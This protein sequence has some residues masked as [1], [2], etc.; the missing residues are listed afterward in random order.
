[1]MLKRKNHSAPV[2]YVVMGL[3]ELFCFVMLLHSLITG[4]WLYALMCLANAVL[5]VAPQLLQRW[6]DLQISAV[7][8]IFLMIFTVLAIIVGT[9]LDVYYLTNWLDLAVHAFSGFLVAAI[10]FQLYS[11]MN[12]HSLE[13]PS[14]A[15]R[16]VTAFCAS[17]AVAVL[18]EFWE[19][20]VFSLFDMDMQHDSVLNR[21]CTSYFTNKDGVSD[22]F[23]NITSMTL[24]ADGKTYE[25]NGYLDM[26]F[27]DT[28]TDMLACFGG[29]IVFLVGV[30]AGKERFIELFTPQR[31]LTDG[32]KT[33][34]S[35]TV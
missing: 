10:G 34:A 16:C 15:Y 1:M 6:L 17:L 21:L 30:F 5:V 13:T 2:V 32:K 7:F 20:F 27:I 24:V 35:E 3:L 23:E 28:M 9:V 25:I 4:Q 33:R 11:I 26:G 19:Y 31:K 29:T 12:R 22:I 14:L 18:W 8:E